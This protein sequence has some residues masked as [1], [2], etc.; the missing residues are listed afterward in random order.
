MNL[1]K[2][3]R[4]VGMKTFLSL[5]GTLLVNGIIAGWLYLIHFYGPKVF[6][7]SIEVCVITLSIICVYVIVQS[8]VVVIMNSYERNK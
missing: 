8:I 6:L 7:L 3:I 4:A 1:K 5:I 2:L